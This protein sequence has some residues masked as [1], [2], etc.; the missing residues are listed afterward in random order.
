ML[1]QSV[2]RRKNRKES[3]GRGGR[4]EAGVTG[5]GNQGRVVRMNNKSAQN[6]V[7]KGVKV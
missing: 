3:G 7:S 6:M 1:L 5:I 4:S 2:R